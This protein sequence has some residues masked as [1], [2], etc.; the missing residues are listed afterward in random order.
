LAHVLSQ[1]RGG[2]VLVE[3]SR[4]GRQLK[5][6]SGHW[7]IVPHQRWCGQAAAAA[8]MA[9]APAGPAEDRAAPPARV[10]RDTTLQVAIDLG[11]LRRVAFPAA[12]GPE[13]GDGA[14][15]SDSSDDGAR[16][17]DSSDRWNHSGND[18]DARSG[19]SSDW[20]NHSGSE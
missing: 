8:P 16:S 20:W 12:G 18:D 14:R 17:G 7:S 19:D 15:S 5:W 10:R 1:P 13:P 3:L 2:W 4:S 11:P 9:V 6:R